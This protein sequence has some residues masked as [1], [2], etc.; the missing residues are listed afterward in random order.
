[1]ADPGKLSASKITTYKGC[2]FAYFLSYIQH[3]KVPSNVKLVFGKSIHYMLD[4]FYDVNFKSPESFAGYWRHYWFSTVGGSFLRGKERERLTV[5]E[6]EFGSKK[7]EAP[8][9]LKIGSHVNLGPEPVG[10]FFGYM[11]L[12]DNILKRFYERHKN[13]KPPEKKE[14]AFGNKKDELF[15]IAGHPVRGVFDRIDEKEGKWYI[16]DYKTD[17]SCPEKDAFTLHR[18]P[19]FTIY[20]LA[21]RELFGKKETAILYYHLR[22][23]NIF[24]THRSEQDYE[25]IKRLVDD[26]AEGIIKDIFVPFYGFHCNMCDLKPA[27]E[28][29]SINHHGGPRIDCLEGKII[30]AEKFTEWDNIDV[31]SINSDSP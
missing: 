25:Y 21:F 7:R 9:I 4:K 1:M 19:Q 29:Y 30:G 15:S 11:K 6:Y 20:S 22:S 23:G 2:S 17:K 12:G 18:H 8:G 3:E 13:Q 14:S 24:K 28:K 10:V 26:V 31:F 27:C 16:T 5:S